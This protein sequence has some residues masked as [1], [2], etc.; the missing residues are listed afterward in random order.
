MTPKE[1]LKINENDKWFA[2]LSQ[3]RKIFNTYSEKE[4]VI[5]YRESFIGTAFLIKGKI[6][7]FGFVCLAKHIRWGNRELLR[8]PL[9]T[10]QLLFRENGEEKVNVVDEEQFKIFERRVLLDEIGRENE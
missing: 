3:E 2:G 6:E 5:A 7:I 4:C 9:K 1:L 8:K 10:I